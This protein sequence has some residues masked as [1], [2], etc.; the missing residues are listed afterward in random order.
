MSGRE[1]WYHQIKRC[2][3]AIEDTPP[4]MLTLI[5]SVQCPTTNYLLDPTTTLPHKKMIFWIKFFSNI[6]KE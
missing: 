5:G 4:L 2:H 3:P 1:S 6:W